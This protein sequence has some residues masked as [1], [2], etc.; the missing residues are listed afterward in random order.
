MGPGEA[1][2]YGIID[3]VIVQKKEPVHK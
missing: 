1:K 3:D 2:E